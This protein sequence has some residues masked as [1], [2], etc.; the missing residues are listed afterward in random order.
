[1]TDRL[2]RFD[3]DGMC[4]GFIVVDRPLEEYAHRTDLTPDQPPDNP[5]GYHARRVNGGWVLQQ[6]AV[7]GQPT[8]EQAKAQKWREM[9]I[10]RAAAS[11]A[12]L[13]TPY[14][15]FDADIDSRNNIIQTAHLMQTEAQSLA[16]ASEPTVDFTLADNSVASLTAGQMVQVA[17]LLAAQIEAAYARGR[18]LR[19]AIE[20]AGTQAE[21]AALSWA[22]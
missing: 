17:L 13:V 9:K 1:M 8:L 18:V 6:D 21:I 2:Y 7:L 3:G 4:L 22:A 10:A 14:G 15:T 20:A 5:I 19:A 12:P 11:Q 16:P